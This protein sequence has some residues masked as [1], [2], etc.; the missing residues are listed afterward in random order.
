M[1]WW[2]YSDDQ[3]GD[4][5][6][7]DDGSGRGYGVANDDID[8]GNENDGGDKVE[9]DVDAYRVDREWKRSLAPS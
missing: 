5:Y 2:W 1:W 6:K 3:E 8:D 4:G 9:N 7:G